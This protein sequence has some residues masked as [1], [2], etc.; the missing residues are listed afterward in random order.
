MLQ[1]VQLIHEIAGRQQYHYL[2]WR[3]LGQKI[4]PDGSVRPKKPALTYQFTIPRRDTIWNGT[5]KRQEKLVLK[6]NNKIL[7]ECQNK[8]Y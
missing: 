3:I 8:T 6:Q 1:F 4:R 2:F 5:F 7:K